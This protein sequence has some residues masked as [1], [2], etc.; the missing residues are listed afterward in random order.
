MTR[1]DSLKL[2][3]FIGVSLAALSAATA[4]AQEQAP[5]DSVS[6]LEEVVVTAS[7]RSENIRELANSVT[8][9]TGADLAETG[10]QSFADYLN[11]APGVQFQAAT[12]GVSNVT[13]RGVGTATIYPDQGQSTTGIYLNDIPLTDPGFALGIPDLNVFDVDRVEVLRGPQGTLFGSATLGGAVNYVLKPVNL[14]DAQFSTLVGTSTT[15]HGGDL[16][17]TANAAINAP[18]VPGVFGVRV[19]GVRSYDVG[20]VDN[21][22]TG[23][24]N[25]NS[26]DVYGLRLNALWQI[27]PDTSLNA[28]SFWD[29]SHSDDNSYAYQQLGELTRTTLVPE[30]LTFTT[31]VNSL[32]LESDLKFAT[33]TLLGAHSEKKQEALSDLTIFYGPPTTSPTNAKTDS[34]M[35][36]ARL[37]SPDDGRL[38]WL[39]GLYYGK[40]SE[41]Y[42]SP[43]IQGGVNV[44]DF[45]VDYDSE[46]ISGFAE[47]TYNLSDTWK[48][49]AGGRYYDIEL[50]TM[51][52]SGLPGTYTIRQGK[53]SESGFSPRVSVTFQPNPD[54]MLY[55]LISRGFRMGGVNLNPPIA[56]FPTPATYGS[57]SLT[58]YEIGVRTSWLDRQLILDTTLFYIDW[59][60]IQLRLSRPDGFAY[61]DNAG[62][63]RSVGVESS[64][65]WAPSPRFDLRA[66]LTY[67]DSELA[68]P[69]NLGR[70]TVIPDGRTLPGASKW[71]ISETATYHFEAESEPYIALSHRYISGAE[72]DFQSRLPV[73]D[74][75][76][77]DLRAGTVFGEADIAVFVTNLTDERGIT[78]ASSMGS[79]TS[80]FYVRPRTVGVRLAWSR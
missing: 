58:N 15:S 64:L 25:A 11:T 46:E 74:Y 21:V 45:T 53:Q 37:V 78:A 17:Y 67:L 80:N 43:T 23:R 10:A 35:F 79:Y 7:K 71:S 19:T 33:L 57:D 47:A 14:N 65:V 18:I 36:E 3:I 39:A 44:G 60:D 66:N 69:L 2:R 62:A 24:D 27:T 48:V 5:P 16:S 51:I 38:K 22:G 40:F 59:K 6:V 1:A 75:S 77:V 72:S 76:L 9:F 13:I 41:N 61:A 12:P 29:R 52:T 28:F 26:H 49:T 55:G 54:L 68:E 73:G 70:G 8:A 31:F 56:S 4:S 32:R 30:T 20:Y 63:A 34:D 50:K 42:P